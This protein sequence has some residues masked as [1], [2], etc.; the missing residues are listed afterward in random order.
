IAT[1]GTNRASSSSGHCLRV[2]SNQVS[3]TNGPAMNQPMPIGTRHDGKGCSSQIIHAA[4]ANTQR[5][6]AW[7][8]GVTS[9]EPTAPAPS[10][11]AG[12][13]RR[14]EAADKAANEHTTRKG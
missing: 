7:M 1:S 9:S 13:R 12:H 8:Y 14:R 10:T 3:A 5:S 4:T 6:E 2:G 11:T